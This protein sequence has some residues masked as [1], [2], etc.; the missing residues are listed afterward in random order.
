MKLKTICNFIDYLNFKTVI[1]KIKTNYKKEINCSGWSGF[2]K[3]LTLNS[4]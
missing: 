4:I 2:L 3:G 1:K